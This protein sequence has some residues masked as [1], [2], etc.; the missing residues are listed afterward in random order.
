MDGSKA[1]EAFTVGKHQVKKHNINVIL[2]ETFKTG[3]HVLAANNFENGIMVERKTLIDENKIVRVVFDDE[4]FNRLFFHK[5]TP[6]PP[7]Y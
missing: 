1:V 6:L 3:L 2:L 7:A 4:H 5:Q